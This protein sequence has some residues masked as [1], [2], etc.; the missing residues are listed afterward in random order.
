MTDLSTL[1]VGDKKVTYRF[2]SS[3]IIRNES[4][5]DGQQGMWLRLSGQ[6]AGESVYTLK[7]AVEPLLVS[8]KPPLLRLI[9]EDVKYMDSSGVGAI[10]GIIQKM[11]KV[12]GNLEIYGLSDVG[13]QLFQI[14]RLSSLKEIVK[15][16]DSSDINP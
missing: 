13:R 2:S 8:P 3:L 5:P 7:Q 9:M 16:G 15:L 10:V 6:L 4:P 14:L 11:R 12:G 1:C